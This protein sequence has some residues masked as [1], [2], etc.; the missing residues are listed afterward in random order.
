[1]ESH[2][3]KHINAVELG[4]LVVSVLDVPCL[5]TCVVDELASLVN[6]HDLR[7]HGLVGEF[8]E[9]W[10]DYVLRIVNKGWQQVF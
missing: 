4:Q 2:N 9:D 3:A 6:Q 5:R 1:M 10:G 8:F 7:I